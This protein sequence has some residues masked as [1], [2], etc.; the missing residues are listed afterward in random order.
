MIKKIFFLFLLS[1][2]LFGLQIDLKTLKDIISSNPQAYKERVILATYYIKHGDDAKAN[3]LLNEALKIKADDKDA[4]KLKQFLKIRQHNQEVLKEASLQQPIQKEDAQKRLQSYY[5][6][7]NYQFYSNLYQALLYNKITLDDPYYIKA[8]YIYFWDGRYKL[9]YDALKHLKQRN[10]IDAAKIHADIC[11]Y[12]G[13]YACA[14]RLYEKLYYSSY[15]M[16]YAIKLINSYIYMGNSAKAQRLYNVL[17]RKYPSSEKLQKI[18]IKLNEIKEKYV[19]EKKEAYEKNPNDITLEGY[20]IALDSLGRTKE[21]L[22][23]LHQHNS[24]IPTKKSLLLEAKYLTWAGKS[25]EALQVLQSEKLTSDLQAKL[26]LGKIYSWENQPD[27]ASRYLHEVIAKSHDEKLL[28][29]AKKALAFVQMWQKQSD[30]AKKSFLVLQKQ[31]PHDR[32]VKEALMELNHNYAGLIKI[33]EKKVRQGGS[34][35]DKKRLADLYISNKEPS[36]AIQY[37]KQYIALHPEDMEATKQLGSLLVDQKDYYQGFGYLEYYAAQKNDAKSAIFLA[38]NYN[39]NGFSK[40]ALDV[41]NKLLEKDPKNQEALQLKAKILKIAPRF[42]TSNSGATIGQYYSD[43]GKKQLQIADTL[44]FNSHYLAS[45]MYYEDYLQNNPTDHAVRLRYAF[46]LENAG[47]YG[48][49]EGEF[50]LMRWTQDSDEVRYHYAYNM[51]KNG[52]LKEAKKEF[53][54]LK[55]S[56]YKPLSAKIQSFLTKWKKDWESQDF[57]RYASHYAKVY[58]NNELWSFRKQQI[59]SHVNF[60]AVSIFDPVYKKLPNGHY[61]IKFFQDYATNRKSDKG[62][63]TVE[64]KCSDKETECKIVKES[65][66]AGKYHKIRLLDRAI[67]NSLKELQRYEKNPTLLPPK[68]L[69]FVNN[70]FLQNSKKKISV[71]KVHKYHDITLAPGLHKD[72]ETQAV[73]L[74]Q[75]YAKANN[76][77]ILQKNIVASRAQAEPTKRNYLAVKG[78]HFKDSEGVIFNSADLFYKRFKIAN[79]VGLGVDAGVFS[80]EQEGVRKHNGI[81]YGISLL[82]NHFTFRLGKND[83]DNFSEIIPTLLYENS[84]KNHSYTLEYTR[85]NGVF[86]TYRLCPYEERIK[87]DHFSISDYVSLKNHS[88]LWANVTANNYSNAD[89]E[90]IGQFDWRFHYDT[91]MDN[92][93]TYNFALDGYYTTHT[94]QNNCFYS[95]HFNDGTFLRID[96][97]YRVNKYLSILGMF[98][99]GYSFHANQFLYKYG[100]LFH[101]NPLKDLSYKVGCM[102]SNSARSGV[103]GNG[104]HYRECKSELEYRW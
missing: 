56:T 54:A 47:L 95:P 19:Q 16:D 5:D 61:K 28:Y 87:A 85:Q 7:S 77:N 63:K 76:V 32:E 29:E 74:D 31:N 100:L 36:K 48:K 30:L 82:Y 62:Y 44:Y 18:G 23:L 17:I 13:K 94:K 8:A 40:E 101:G 14:A 68:M 78:Y 72:Y 99:A 46:A 49:A 24:K 92:R 33:Y 45:L 39:W 42:T 12:Q 10:N 26:M 41:L 60:I 104:Y 97:D 83:F 53:I 73:A 93:L 34:D 43:L 88:N 79:N 37:L 71:E 9:S 11:Y 59:F 75:M 6:A 27:L 57:S 2:N 51:M 103:S 20:A 65:W 55:N 86:Y 91:I 35:A 96:P 66:Q 80:V 1:V 22:S 21:N 4:L 64:V 58:T 69:S 70:P 50:A 102:R 84:Y 90:L 25:K 52:K 67:D 98:G 89:L 38:K 3:K 81:R 15:D